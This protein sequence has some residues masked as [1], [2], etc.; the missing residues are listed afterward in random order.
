MSDIKKGLD[1]CLRG[2]APVICV[3][4]FGI[5]IGYIDKEDAHKIGSPMHMAVSIFVFNEDGKLLVQQRSMEKEIAPGV[6][7]NTCCAHPKP[8]QLVKEAAIERLAIE[9]G[10]RCDLTEICT[11]KLQEDL[12]NGQAW[13][14]FDHIFVG[15][16]NDK[17]N[18]NPVEVN[19]LSWI[20][21][22]DLKIDMNLNPDKYSGV[23]KHALE[24]AVE[25]N[26]K[27]VEE[28][29]SMAKANRK[30]IR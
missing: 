9:T 2:G 23:L 14:E 4:E 27:S 21:I 15:R 6:W 12:G 30:V 25:F 24:K 20:D 19:K 16:S 8:G 7:S 1:G 13:N 29:A 11:M 28:N 10:I 26:A 18:P 3:N 22:D 5:P 17:P